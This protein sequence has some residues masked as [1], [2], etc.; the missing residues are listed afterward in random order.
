MEKRQ[1]GNN[2]PYKRLLNTYL[3]KFVIKPENIPDSYW[4]AQEKILFDRDGTRINLVAPLS[5][6]E[7]AAKN[8]H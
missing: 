4:A 6:Q 1:A 8:A 5:E 7:Q 2:R 3:D